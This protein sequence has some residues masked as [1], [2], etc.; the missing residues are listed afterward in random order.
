VLKRNYLGTTISFV[1]PE[2][3]YKGYVVDCTYKFIKHMNKYAVNLWLRRSDISDRLP[4]GSQGINTQYIA[5]DKENIQN[6]IGNMIEQA[7]NSTFF[8]EYI[9]RF[10]YYVKCFNYGNTIFEEKWV[11]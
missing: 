2:N 9:E 11:N 5:S 10:E 8:D 3:Q 7:A 1:L 6:D 4:I